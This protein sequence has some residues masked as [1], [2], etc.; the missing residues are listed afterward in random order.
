MNKDEATRETRDKG[1]P[2]RI[3]PQRQDQ[4]DKVVP[5]IPPEPPVLPSEPSK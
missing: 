1:V 4:F 2:T 3:P 5:P